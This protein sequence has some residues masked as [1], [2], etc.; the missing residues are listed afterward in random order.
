V[1]KLDTLLRAVPPETRRR[2]RERMSEIWTRFTYARAVTGA[3]QFLRDGQP[4]DYLQDRAVRALRREQKRG[5]V[6]A[7]DS[8]MLALAAKRHGRA[9]SKRARPTSMSAPRR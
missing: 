4:R 3:A 9:A 5:A 6:D 2:M 1:E 7:Y 8:I